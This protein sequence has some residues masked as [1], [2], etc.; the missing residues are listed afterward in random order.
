MIPIS[1]PNSNNYN[2]LRTREG[3]STSTNKRYS[4]LKNT[5]NRGETNNLNTSERPLRNE[6]TEII[7]SN[8]SPNVSSDFQNIKTTNNNNIGE[9]NSRLLKINCDNKKNYVK[10]QPI[11]KFDQ[12]SK[13]NKDQEMLANYLINNHDNIEYN[14]IKNDSNSKMI[15]NRSPNNNYYDNSNLKDSRKNFCEAGIISKNQDKQSDYNQ[16]NDV[17]FDK[18]KSGKS[19]VGRIYITDIEEN[20]K[21]EKEEQMG[22]NFMKK[23]QSEPSYNSV[24]S[25]R[26]RE[27]DKRSKNYPKNELVEETL[28]GLENNNHLIKN[29]NSKR[30]DF[31]EIQIKS[32]MKSFEQLVEEKMRNNQPSPTTL[33][34]Q[35]RSP[36]KKESPDKRPFLKKKDRA[37][38]IPSEYKKYKYYN[39]NFK[40]DEYDNEQTKNISRKVN[41]N[42]NKETKKGQSLRNK[43]PTKSNYK[44][45]K[46]EQVK[47]I[48][49]KKNLINDSS[50]PIIPDPKN[51]QIDGS[52]KS[53]KAS[54]RN[55]K[56]N[57][58]QKMINNNKGDSNK[59]IHTNY[60]ENIEEQSN[61]VVTRVK[62]IKKV[63]HSPQVRDFKGENKKQLIK[64][65]INNIKDEE[66]HDNTQ[67]GP[68][69]LVKQLFYKDEEKKN[70]IKKM[71]EDKKKREEVKEFDNAIQ[72]K[73]EVYLI[74]N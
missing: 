55:T 11:Q 60:I 73:I 71:E 20:K 53:R 70:K 56:T 27:L 50:I 52:V 61:E 40:D 57:K 6:R 28:D 14:S 31:E 2:N 63:I 68:S 9:F 23:D 47:I 59:D 43:E 49:P 72:S 18:T 62:E 41:K 36:N 13:L 7:E 25:N 19:E 29:Q 38:K 1:C 42:A 58:P 3:H 48:G 66:R 15:F 10:N 5:E 64:E 21:N 12:I 16:K 30:N 45:I 32:N 69:K 54:N 67:E 22:K 4:T 74:R 8:D 39:S 46:E 34:L 35:K 33:Q 26:K 37:I 44:I 24:N 17:I 65:E 51:S